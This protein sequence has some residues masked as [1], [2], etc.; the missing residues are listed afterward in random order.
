MTPGSVAIISGCP[1]SGK[2]TL[3][4]QLA[5]T[6]DKY[7]HL[8]TDLFFN[9]MRGLIDPSLPEARHQNENI[10][11]QYCGVANGF[12][13]DGYHVLVDGV[14]GPW[15]LSIV[16]G[17]LR[18]FR[19]AILHPNLTTAL[20]R[21]ASRREKHVSPE[22]ISKMHSE[23]TGCLPEYEAYYFEDSSKFRTYADFPDFHQ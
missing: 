21:G 14:V 23:F 15:M 16:T 1:A 6:S 7:L 13:E 12:R 3:A 8:Q 19:Y 20:S 5:A 22:S 2:S 10:V 18:T 17:A 4:R 9:S 11:R